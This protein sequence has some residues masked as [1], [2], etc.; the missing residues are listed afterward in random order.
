M[1]QVPWC[2]VAIVLA[3]PLACTTTD[4]AA[5][6]EQNAYET[7]IARLQP[8]VER[9]YKGDPS[10]YAELFADEMTYFDPGSGGRLEGITALKNHYAP[11]K[12]K[13]SVPRFEILDPKIQLHSDI[14]VLTY[15]LKE[16]A[17]DGSVSV[18]W[19]ATEVYRGIG[20]EW[21][22]IH[23]HWSPVQETE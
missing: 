12:G 11:L 3:L 15:G 8:A 1:R 7:I 5:T 9:W 6:D 14:A 22:I 23:A 20:D 13:I 17:S 2:L 10:G 16:Y 19:N 4:R 18:R 21:R